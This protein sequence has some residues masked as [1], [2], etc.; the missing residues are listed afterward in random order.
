M[1]PQRLRQIEELY[2]S[3][4]EIGEAAL[5][6][7]D[8]EL[9]GEVEKLLAQDSEGS[10][11]LDQRA[12]DLFTDCTQTV[13]TAGARLGPYILEAPL[14]QGGMG[15]VFRAM[16]PRL[17]RAVAIK[18]SHKRFSDRF[19]REARAIAALNH[20]NVCTLH[21]VGPNYL[22]MELV[23][24]ESL[25]ARLDRGKLSIE[26]T[27]RFGTQIANALAAA[28]AKGIV[29]RDLKPA[30]I[31]VTKS[32]V[33]V[34]DFGLAK[35][36]VDPALTAAGAVIG[37]PAYMAPEQFEGKEADART[38]IY[39]LGL[40]LSAMVTG[41]PSTEA[42]AVPP[43]LG[44]AIQRCLET[45]PDERWQSARDL[46]WELESSATVPLAASSRSRSGLLA[47]ALG[48][49]TL[50]LMALALVHFREQAPPLEPVRMSVLLPE[51]SPPLSLAVSPDGRQIAVVLVKEGKQQIWVRALD[52]LEPTALDGTDGAAHPF[53]SPDS[54]QIAFFAD[55]KL[56]KIDRSGGPVETL[57]DALAVLGGTWN[58]NGDILLGGLSRVQR[59]PAAGGAVTDLPKNAG[60]RDVYPFFLPD[61]QHYLAT[62]GGNAGS[63]E[64]GVWLNSMN[65]PEARRILQDVSNAEIVNAPPGSQ[66]GA[67][68][69]TRAG[70]LMALPFDMK[71]L[72]AAGDVFPV[73][74]GITGAA[75]YW[76][77]AASGQG[78]LAY[79]SGPRGP[80]QYV[81]RDRR[82]QNLG[83]AGEAGNVVAISPDG[84][85]LVGDYNGNRVL[86]LARGLATQLSFGSGNTNPIWSSDGRYIAYA[87]R[88][89]VYRK[90]A[91]GAGAE[92]LLVSANTLVAP[93]SWSPDGR[94]LLYAQIHPGTGSDL[95]ALPLEGERKPFPVVQT[96][97]N[98]DQGQF[99]PD[100]HWVAYTSNESRL[101][102][103]YVIPFPPSSSGGKWL[104]SR[105]GG[106]Q[107][108]WRR[109]GK[110]LFYISPESKMMAVEV[111]TQ[112]VFQAGNP[113]ALFLT[114]IVDT[115]IRT[116][117]MS[118]DI[119]PD[120]RFLII[121]ENAPQTSS[122]T[123]VLNWR[124]G[125]R[126]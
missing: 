18:I 59:V 41:K 37:T 80:R 57:C 58:R 108:R 121:T 1:S 11:L 89:G 6:G 12:A 109:D 45:D 71:R 54:R 27:I 28:H 72:E 112:P 66:V 126:K 4:R 118:W 64:A 84:K 99:S 90:P 86:E 114:E 79:V 106:V 44:R 91:N 78:V 13:V 53:W 70:T 122:V 103:I 21:D 17:G 116:G 92:E 68:L 95:M 32:G 47:G 97:A 3:V 16:D 76:L 87:G 100:G 23:E 43:P 39:A 98:E 63:P 74:Q 19:E 26:Q 33:K 25:A 107:P 15:Q 111:N 102:E 123:V 34:L 42:R 5:A 82:G 94:F 61:G 124:A 8:P 7:A 49:V 10:K 9:R 40:V 56:K 83:V 125:I 69:F 119:A 67:V 77:A 30:N 110:E 75:L 88:G 22:V 46:K 115:G 120:G 60:A 104:V 31:M 48:L 96:P 81:W 62:R 93:K 117:P 101:S 24:G 29:H 113:Q 2:H 38:D 65:G 51:K 52:A 14:G 20:P 105:G 73:A 55:A 50:L 35:S 85:Q 36:G